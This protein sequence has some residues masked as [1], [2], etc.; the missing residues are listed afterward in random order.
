MQKQMIRPIQGCDKLYSI[1]KVWET[2]SQVG[3][4][5]PSG[6]LFEELRLDESKKIRGEEEL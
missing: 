3:R 5:S 2:P 6:T 4:N 1:V